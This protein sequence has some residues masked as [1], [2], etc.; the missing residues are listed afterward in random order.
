[1]TSE[2]LD[3]V[4][5]EIRAINVFFVSSTSDF[6]FFEKLLQVFINHQIV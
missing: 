6:E 5:D 1:M 4:L 2:V 3:D